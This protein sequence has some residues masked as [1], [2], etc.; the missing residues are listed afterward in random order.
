MPDSAL[1]LVELLI[2][3]IFNVFFSFVFLFLNKISYK[4]IQNSIPFTEI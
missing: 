2:I 1:T 4:E 3:L